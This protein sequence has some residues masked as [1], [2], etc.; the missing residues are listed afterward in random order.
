MPEELL[1]AVLRNK[2]WMIVGRHRHISRRRRIYCK[3]TIEMLLNC[4]FRIFSCSSLCDSS[5]FLCPRSN[6]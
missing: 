1:L 5:P 4:F 3:M 2:R 6:I